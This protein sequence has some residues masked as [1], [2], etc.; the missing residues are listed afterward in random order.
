MTCDGPRVHSWREPVFD[1][2]LPKGFSDTP[3]PV[4]KESTT[5]IPMTW[6]RPTH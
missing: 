1:P 4:S 5:D 2:T 6:R 3:F